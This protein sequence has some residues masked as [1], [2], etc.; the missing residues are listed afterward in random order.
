MNEIE[1]AIKHYEGLQKRYTT[2]HNGKH[3]EFVKTAIAALHEKQKRDK[4]C[5][6]CNDARRTGCTNMGNRIYI[7]KN[8]DGYVISDRYDNRV[9]A[10]FC[11]MCGR[12][13]KEEH[14]DET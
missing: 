4:G 9:K 10:S 11:P 2:Q 13:L 5:W 7:E 3:C 8:E 6:A 12:S 14:N 1:K